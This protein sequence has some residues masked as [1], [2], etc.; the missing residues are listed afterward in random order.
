MVHPSS[1]DRAL[2]SLVVTAELVN[3]NDV[4]QDQGKDFQLQV[5]EKEVESRLTRKVMKPWTNDLEAILL[6]VEMYTLACP[7]RYI[8]TIRL[9]YIIDSRNILASIQNA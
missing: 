7:S 4:E 8:H 6:Q 3:H 9:R 2:P 1:L 5:I